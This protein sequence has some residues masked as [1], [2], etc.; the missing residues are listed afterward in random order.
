MVRV[1]GTVNGTAFVTGENVQING[2]ING[3]LFVAAQNATITGE[4][5]GNVYFAGMTIIME[6]EVAQDTFMAGQTL[7]IGEDASLGRDLFTAGSTIIQAGAVERHMFGAGDSIVLNG[8]IGGDVNLD[9]NRLSLGNAAVINGDLTYTSDKEA[10][11]ESGAQVQG[12]TDFR[13]V[14]RNRQ[15]MY[16]RQMRRGFGSQIWF[17]VLSVLSAALIWLVIKLW[18]PTWWER[19]AQPLLERPLAT[20]GIGLLALL[21]TPLLGIL[22]MITII[23]IPL[24]FILLTG[25]GIMLYLA[26]IFVSV[27]AALALT[28]RIHGTK[29]IKESWLVVLSLLI[30][31][32]IGMIPILN[33]FLWVLMAIAGLG[34]FALSHYKKASA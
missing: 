18:R 10:N 26:K 1:D 12:E 31:G 28:R 5:T 24:A 3:D 6:G 8:S 32:L 23:G 34:T 7:T 16:N 19:T 25:Y 14:E 11:M 33:F 27:A 13:Q 2:T 17:A 30:L 9:L 21:V 4:I 22:L 20:M 15:D 29:R